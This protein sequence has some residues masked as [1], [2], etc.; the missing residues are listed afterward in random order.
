MLVQ[1]S[2]AGFSGQPATL[3][4]VINDQSGVLVIAKSVTYTEERL[5]GAALVTNLDLPDYDF[6]FTDA[7]LRES[8]R[9]FFTRT[10]QDMLV[11]AADMRRYDPTNRIER[12]AVE[13]SGPRYRISPDI[14]NGQ[15]AV[16]A[17]VAFADSQKPVTASISAMNE[18]ADF[19]SVTTI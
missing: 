10:G 8:I 13:E 16:L 4:C 14:D 9:S 7:H 11:I 1:V 15:V 18:L 12:D 2:I 17:A 6:R 5:S 3:A 19:Y